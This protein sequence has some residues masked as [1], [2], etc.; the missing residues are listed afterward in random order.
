[1]KENNKGVTLI[2]LAITIIVLLIISGITI[3]A[4]SYNA[5]KA[6][7][8]KLLSEIIMVQN[9]VLQR[10][11]KAELIN[12]HYPGQKLTEIGIDIDEVISRLNLEM[13]EGNESIEKKD[14]N[15]S[16]YYLLS[17]ENGGIKELNIKNAEDEYI[18]NYV[19]GEVINYTNCVTGK[20]EP[21]YVYSIENRN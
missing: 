17:N 19:T 4:G 7:D 16:N 11:T 18:V 12:G 20:G 6:K 1:M 10:K 5:E 9:A 8:N 13:A 3:T 14:N 2:A 15:K 21:V